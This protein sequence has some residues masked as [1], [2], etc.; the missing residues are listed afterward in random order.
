MILSLC[1][2]DSTTPYIDTGQL[3]TS[4]VLRVVVGGPLQGK[5]MWKIYDYNEIDCQ[6]YSTRIRCL[7]FN[8]WLLIA[9]FVLQTFL[10][11]A[12]LYRKKTYLFHCTFYFDFFGV[13]YILDVLKFI[14]CVRYFNV[15][16][17]IKYIVLRGLHIYP[18]ECAILHTSY[19]IY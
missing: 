8:L 2:M 19:I 12:S 18:I 3:T 4:H 6:N 17:I 10:I 5:I 16:L 1:I 15:R 7:S 14:F 13:V 9:L 11:L